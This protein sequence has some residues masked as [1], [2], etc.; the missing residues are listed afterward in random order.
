MIPEL[1]NFKCQLVIL[2]PFVSTLTS[3]SLLLPFVS[4]R[5]LLAVVEEISYLGDYTKS[6][7]PI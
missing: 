6:I 4:S 1:N 2:I 5:S 7:Q 3:R